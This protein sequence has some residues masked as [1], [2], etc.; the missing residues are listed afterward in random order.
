MLTTEEILFTYDYRRRVLYWKI[1]ELYWMEILRLR[2][3]SISVPRWKHVCYV[4]F[5]SGLALMGH[6]HHNHN[7]SKT[8]S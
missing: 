4:M 7:Q 5:G 6:A 2:V 3:V 1:G 8:K